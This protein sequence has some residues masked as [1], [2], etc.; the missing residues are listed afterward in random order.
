MYFFLSQG[1]PDLSSTSQC[2]VAYVF[3]SI[4]SIALACIE[5]CCYLI[6]FQEIWNHDNT[7]GVSILKPQALKKR[8]KSSMVSIFGQI[9]SWSMQMWYLIMFAITYAFFDPNG[10]IQYLKKYAF[11]IKSLEFALIPLFQ[12]TASITIKSKKEN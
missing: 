7:I 1:L 11:F 8:N 9:F 12:I 10:E 3:A 5:L 4:I 2:K 6:F